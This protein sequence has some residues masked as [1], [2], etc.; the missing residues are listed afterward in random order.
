VS[1]E[2]AAVNGLLQTF[3]VNGRFKGDYIFVFT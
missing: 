1:G 3:A 2:Q